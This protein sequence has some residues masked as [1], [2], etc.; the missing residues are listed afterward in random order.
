MQKTPE[1]K[2]EKKFN[3]KYWKI[4]KSTA[5][6]AKGQRVFLFSRNYLTDG[7]FKVVGG[8]VGRC[9]HANFFFFSSVDALHDG[10]SRGDEE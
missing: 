8:G 6:I 5:H 7:V 10:T 3:E 1:K 2:F 9:G 4:V